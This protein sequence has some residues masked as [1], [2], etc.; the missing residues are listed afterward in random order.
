MLFRSQIDIRFAFDL[1]SGHLSSTR[2]HFFAN[3][4]HGSFSLIL[5]VIAREG[6]RAQ[7]ATRKRATQYAAANRS[8]RDY[9]ITR[10]RGATRRLRVMTPRG[11][12][13]I[14]DS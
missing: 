1:S 6:R 13:G 4:A 12:D 5:C 8:A 11:V 10:W 2:D 14:P 3:R 7:R 9:W